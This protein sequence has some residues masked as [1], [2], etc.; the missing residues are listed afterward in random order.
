M[1]MR[2]HGV[3]A[4]GEDLFKTQ[5]LLDGNVD[6]N[7]LEASEHRIEELREAQGRAWQVLGGL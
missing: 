4:T 5:V 2:N 6:G 3:E 7:C 1:D